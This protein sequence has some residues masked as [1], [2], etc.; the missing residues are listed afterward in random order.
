[1]VVFL[2]KLGR[3]CLLVRAAH[4]CPGC[5]LHYKWLEMVSYAGVRHRRRSEA[6]QVLPF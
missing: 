5:G 2:C 3:V 4:R 1:M 6:V